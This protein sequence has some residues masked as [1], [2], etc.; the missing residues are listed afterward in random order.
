MHRGALWDGHQ[1]VLQWLGLASPSW[2]LN[3]RGEDA[4]ELGGRTHAPAA[5]AAR[6][7]AEFFEKGRKVLGLD[8]TADLLDLQGTVLRSWSPSRGEP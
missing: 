7:M 2:C 8:Y 5:E 3:L 6:L 1:Q 4:L